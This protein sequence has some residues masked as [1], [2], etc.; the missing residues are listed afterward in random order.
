MKTFPQSWPY[1]NK[2]GVELD[3]NEIKLTIRETY[4]R[5]KGI[6]FGLELVYI[7]IWA[8][9]NVKVKEAFRGV[10]ISLALKAEKRNIHMEKKSLLTLGGLDDYDF[11]DET[12][13]NSEEAMI[14]RLDAKSLFE[15]VELEALDNLHKVARFRAI[16][17]VKRKL[18]ERKEE[19]YD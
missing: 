17:K 14:L 15:Q 6:D 19:Y 7:L 12:F 8:I 5:S 11:V 4:K 16:N 2:H 3:L 9:D 13:G 18:K 10:V 1:L